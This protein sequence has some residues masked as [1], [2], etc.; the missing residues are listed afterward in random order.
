ML[1]EHAVAG[2]FAV[3]A[4]SSA[5]AQEVDPR[6]VRFERAAH[7]MAEGQRE[8]AYPELV[9]L[10]EDGA[11]FPEAYLFR[12][13]IERER[14]DLAQAQRAFE[15][16]LAVAPSHR[17]LRL[18]LAVTLSWKG[19]TEKALASYEAVLAA[20]PDDTVAAVGRGRMLFWLGRHEA[21]VEAF[22]A[23]L[24]QEPENL[25]AMVGLADVHRAR[26]RRRDA[27][28][29]YDRALTIDPAFQPAVEGK[30]KLSEAT[31][32]ELRLDLGLSHGDAGLSGRGGLGATVFLTPELSLVAG[33]RQDVQRNE[34]E[35]ARIGTVSL[36]ARVGERLAIEAGYQLLRAEG[37][38]IHRI[39]LGLSFRATDKWTLLLSTRPGVREDG[40]FEHL[41]MLGSQ[42]QVGPFR[43]MLQVFRGDHR[44][45]HETVFALSGELDFGVFGVRVGV[46]GAVAEQHYGT[47]G[48][49]L[50]LTLGRRHDLL[51]GYDHLTLGGRHVSTLGYRVRL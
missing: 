46:A 20:D 29:L 14:G 37:D 12:G 5:N 6:G 39:P 10:T 40:R 45:Q 18:E 15:A 1:R 42:H 24:A 30:A 47:V 17:S 4:A 33:F 7:L 9:A 50:R 27:R 44:T 22:E 48:A 51:L 11:P 35:M 21:A 25:E 23:V 16:G 49:Q 13:S 32:A 8:Q 19:E 36:V 41:T 34:L 28:E 3:L 38:R 26:L 31:R 2:L 43:W